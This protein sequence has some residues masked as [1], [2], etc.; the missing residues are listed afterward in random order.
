[1]TNDMERK[2]YH[3]PILGAWK[4][5]ERTDQYGD[6]FIRIVDV[7]HMDVFDHWIDCYEII[8]VPAYGRGIRDAGKTYNSSA[9]AKLAADEIWSKLHD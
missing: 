7:S 2:L 6:V 1:M 9:S 3:K 8:Y 5:N 4:K